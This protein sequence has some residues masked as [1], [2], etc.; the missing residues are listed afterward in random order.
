MKYILFGLRD[1][2]RWS[3]LHPAERAAFDAA[4][5]HFDEELR[6][7]GHVLAAGALSPDAD[8]LLFHARGDGEAATSADAP[9]SLHELV[10]IEARDLNDAIRIASNHPAARIGGPLGWVVEIRLLGTLELAPD[11]RME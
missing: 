10:I 5:H 11:Q 9:K 4:R 3:A 8:A 7:A 1:E 6:V 2:H